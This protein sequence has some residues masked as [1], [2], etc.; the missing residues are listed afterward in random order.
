[1]W[2]V[3][4]RLVTAHDQPALGGIYKLSALRD[5]RGAWQYRL[6]RSDATIK[7]SDPGILQV[8]RF[9][10]GGR[11]LADALYD[12]FMGF[13][14]PELVSH[15]RSRTWKVP[16]SAEG[17]DLLVP[18]LRRGRGVQAAPPPTA[19]REFAAQQLAELPEETR[20]LENPEPYFVG[21]ERQLAA[22]KKSLLAE[23]ENQLR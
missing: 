5:D 10:G 9:H 23:V 7:V 17:A 2:G 12:E 21:L 3:G 6:K 19:L 1:V 8:R 16:L 11:L 13:N 20:R 18:V 22:L 15:D 4:T 14:A